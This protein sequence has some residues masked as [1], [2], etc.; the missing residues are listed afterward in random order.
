MGQK[1]WKKERVEVLWCIAPDSLDIDVPHQQARFAI[2][3]VCADCR[4]RERRVAVLIFGH[5]L[6]ITGMRKWKLFTS[7]Q[8]M[9]C[10][11]P[12]QIADSVCAARC[13]VAPIAKGCF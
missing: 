7:Q 13:Q 6:S 4:G 10:W 9:A 8:G 5:R 12:A 11:V 3:A 2:G 1:M